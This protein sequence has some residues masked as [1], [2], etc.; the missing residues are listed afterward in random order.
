M[1]GA[2][3][4]LL[5][6]SAAAPPSL[7]PSPRPYDDRLPA[8]REHIVEYIVYSFVPDDPADDEDDLIREQ[9]VQALSDSVQ[10]QRL[11]LDEL[12]G[13]EDRRHFVAWCCEQTRRQLGERTSD[14]FGVCSD[15]ILN[16]QDDQRWRCARLGDCAQPTKTKS[17]L[18]AS[19]TAVRKRDARENIYIVR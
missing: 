14:D 16:D 2:L 11:D 3:A 6:F 13:G 8:K 17:N 12:L 5:L 15:D 18:N 1:S 4:H 7:L 9:A 10:E 19:M